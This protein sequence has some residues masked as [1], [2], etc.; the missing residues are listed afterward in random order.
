MSAAT[1]SA[2]T[3]AKAKE[4]VQ[5]KGRDVIYLNAPAIEF[6]ENAPLHNTDKRE[7]YAI[8]DE[9]FQ[10][11]SGGGDVY[12][13][14]GSGSGITVTMV[15]KRGAEQELTVELFDFTVK[16]YKTIT[17]VRSGNT[18]V[19]KIW[20]KTI[21]TEVLKNGETV[22]KFKLDSSGN[23][24]A[25]LDS[26]GN[27]VL[28][29]VTGEDGNFV[30]TPTPEGIALGWAMAYNNE[31]N[32]A[33]EKILD[34]YSNGIDD[35]DEINEKEGSCGGDGTGDGSGGDGTG[36][37]GSGDD[38]GSGG[39]K[40]PD[41]NYSSVTIPFEIPEEMNAY[42]VEYDYDGGGTL[43]W[44]ASE[45]RS[46]DKSGATYIKPSVKFIVTKDGG[47]KS[48]KEYSTSIRLVGDTSNCSFYGN[49]H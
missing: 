14:S 33:L 32:S 1:G 41:K 37:D 24:T 18:A 23:A 35:C 43:Y 46:I 5:I 2:S 16:T 19:E 38:S 40:L 28:N 13:V 48:Y 9:L 6:P 29:G 25:V 3:S 36:G 20:T 7:L 10:G 47:I 4:G 30:V 15:K 17:T 39:I 12:L 22:W 31:Q 21:V 26:A 27:D 49:I 34:A 8:L 45:I 42:S 11:G 44:F